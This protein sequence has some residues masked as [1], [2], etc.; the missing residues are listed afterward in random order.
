MFPKMNKSKKVVAI[1]VAKMI[2][3]GK[4]KKKAKV[5][6]KKKLKTSYMGG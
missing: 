6:V 4:P 3:E 2:E 1:N 5:R